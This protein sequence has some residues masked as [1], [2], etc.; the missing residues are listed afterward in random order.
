MFFILLSRWCK[1]HFSLL[2]M[3]RRMARDFGHYCTMVIHLV[4]LFYGV[5]P[6]VPCV[7]RTA[8]L[9]ACVLHTA[10][11]WPSVLTYRLTTK[12]TFIG[13]SIY[14][15]KIRNTVLALTHSGKRYFCCVSLIVFSVSDS[16]NSCL[17]FKMITCNKS[18]RAKRERE[19][20]CPECCVS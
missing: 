10:L 19:N 6:H 16:Y 5:K 1:V 17:V 11:F 9:Q 4:H 3:S 18:V 12:T 20:I 14:T 2:R 15:K 7:A 13:V 8:L